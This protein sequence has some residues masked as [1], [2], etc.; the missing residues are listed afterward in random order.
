MQPYLFPYLGYFHLVTAA[1]EFVFYDDVHYIKQGWINRNNILVGG[2]PLR[3]SVPIADASS[4]RPIKDVHVTGVERWFAKFAKTLA[5]AYGHA[6]CYTDVMPMIS[7]VFTAPHTSIADLAIASIQETFAYLQLPFR[8]IRSSERFPQSQGMERAER[9]IHITR[10]L[11]LSGY[12]NA[13]GG[14]DL[15]DKPLFAK[16]GIH[17]SFVKSEAISYPQHGGEFVPNL[18]IIDVLMFNTKPAVCHL[19]QRFSLD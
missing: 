8:Y 15:Y 10:E 19:L 4:F 7:K 3:F 6:P 9:L 16:H 13:A 14:K 17:L 11:E 5:Q 12:V 2:K 18:S 1:E